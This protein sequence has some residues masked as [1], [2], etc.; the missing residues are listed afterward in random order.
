VAILGVL[1]S[2]AVG[3][4]LDPG[5]PPGST[6]KTLQQVEPRI[7]ISSVPFTIAASGSFYLTGDVIAAPNTAGITIAASDVTID[8]NG[9]A[10]VGSTAADDGIVAPLFPSYRNLTVRNGT[11]TG[12]RNGI[13]TESIHGAVYEDLVLRNNNGGGLRAGGGSL[14]DHVR[15]FSNG[16]HGILVNEAHSSYDPTEGSIIRSS[17]ANGNGYDGIQFNDYQNPLREPGG[18]LIEDNIASHNGG[19]LGAPYGAGIRINGHR[20]RVEGNNVVNNDGFGINVT[21]G[22][23][24]IVG[25]SGAFNLNATGADFAYD[26]FSFVG[27]NFAPEETSPTVT[28][29][30]SNV[31]Y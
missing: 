23:N 24:Y 9:Y 28:N 20:A 27:G 29:P 15:A 31:N 12:W 5:D 3:G 10:L 17:I 21:S 22:N 1:A 13:G 16:D 19:P 6:M 14:V 11:I 4:P 30:L 18:V 25:N 26:N 2:R 8:L 7:P